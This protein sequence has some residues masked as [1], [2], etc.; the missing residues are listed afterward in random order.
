MCVSGRQEPTQPSTTRQRSVVMNVASLRRCSPSVSNPGHI[1]G[2]VEGRSADPS[3]SSRAASMF[4]F[5]GVD[6]LDLMAMFKDQQTTGACLL[7]KMLAVV[8]LPAT[9]VILLS[10]LLLYSAVAVHRQSNAAID[11]L[12]SFYQVDQLV[13]N[14][15]VGTHHTAHFASFLFFFSLQRLVS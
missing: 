10:A 14:L 1:P 13:T 2:D 5:L 4:S 8:G 3:R 11:Q 9:A 7:A 12:L 15:Q 6:R